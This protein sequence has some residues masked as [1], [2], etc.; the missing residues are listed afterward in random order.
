MLEH[1]GF[2]PWISFKVGDMLERVCGIDIKFE[3]NEA[4]YDSPT[5]VALK[6][7]EEMCGNDLTTS[8]PPVEQALEFLSRNLY[9]LKAPPIRDRR[10]GLQEF[11][12]ILCKWGSHLNG[13]YPLSKDTIEMRAELEQWARIPCPSGTIARGVLDSTPEVP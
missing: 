8:L 2:G 12:T 7:V 1:R 10:L 3:L 11:E 5:K 4:M 9:D 6:L 13:H